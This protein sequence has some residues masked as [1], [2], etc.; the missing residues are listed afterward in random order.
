[1][2]VVEDNQQ[3]RAIML[4]KGTSRD[5]RSRIRWVLMEEWDPIGVK[6]VPEAADEYDSYIGGIFELLERNASG[7]EVAEYLRRIEIDKMGLV[8][9]SGEPLMPEEWRNMAVQSLMKVREH[10]Q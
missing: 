2:R 1:M 10:F 7:Q 4:D 3:W 6:D 5:I 9:T 8:N